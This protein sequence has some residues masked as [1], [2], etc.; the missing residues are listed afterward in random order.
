MNWTRCSCAAAKV[1]RQPYFLAVSTE[2]TGFGS[3]ANSWKAAQSESLSLSMTSGTGMARTVLRRSLRGPSDAGAAP[4]NALA[5]G[6]AG[7]GGKGGGMTKGRD[8]A[9]GSGAATGLGEAA[10]ACGRFLALNSLLKGWSE[11]L[12]TDYFRPG[13]CLFSLFS[14]YFE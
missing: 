3:E 11:L 5:P 6:A 8:R 14:V 9:A 4:A 13:G 10:T 7:S 2:A 12:L 1:L